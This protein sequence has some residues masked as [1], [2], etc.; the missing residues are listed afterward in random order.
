MSRKRSTSAGVDRRHFLG[1]TGAAAVGAATGALNPSV[2]FAS[3]PFNPLLSIGFAEM[4]PGGQSVRLVGADRLL[5]GDPAFISR[6]ARVSIKSFHRQSSRR[7]AAGGAAIE[8]VYPANGYE[9]ARY[10]RFRSWS[11]VG[12]EDYDSVGG[13]ISFNVPVH[14]VNGLE[15]RITRLQTNDGDGPARRRAAAP[16]LSDA[17]DTSEFQ[18]VSLALGSVTGTY[19]LQRGVYVIAFRETQRDAAPA[20]GAYWLSER[21]GE[22]V[23]GTSGGTAADFT[24]AVI[25]VDYAT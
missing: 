16:A 13:R 5:M 4:E 20:W 3:E 15:L 2:L 8:A 7:G 6:A 12:R 17:R 9:P 1:V 19:K 21:S 25:G 23:A 24:Y 18:R 14:G 10:P 11:Y 22:L